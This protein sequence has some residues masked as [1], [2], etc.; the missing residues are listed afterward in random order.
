MRDPLTW[1]VER[2][3][4]AEPQGVTGRVLLR[5]GLLTG[6]GS[7]ALGFTE[8]STGNVIVD[9][10]ARLILVLSVALA[11]WG[12]LQTRTAWRRGYLH[13]RQAM[14]ASLVEAIQRGMPPHEWVLAE[15]ERDLLMLGLTQEDIAHM[16]R[17]VNERLRDED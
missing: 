13:G 8:T 15:A 16:H 14:M 12:V 5:V 10:L 2:E 11:S 17:I 9:F 1:L 4:A 3:I 6:A 7:M